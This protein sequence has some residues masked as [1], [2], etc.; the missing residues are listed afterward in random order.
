MMVRALARAPSRKAFW[1][2]GE[3]MAKTSLRTRKPP[4]A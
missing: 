4:I 1:S 3:S 2:S